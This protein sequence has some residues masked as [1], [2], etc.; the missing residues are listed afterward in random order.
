MVTAGDRFRLGGWRP[1]GGALSYPR[2]TM[3]GVHREAAG[4][5]AGVNVELGTRAGWRPMTMA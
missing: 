2:R 4:H 5:G 1:G 3:S